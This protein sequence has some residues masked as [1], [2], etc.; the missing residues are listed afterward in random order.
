MD[1]IHWITSSKQSKSR[2]KRQADACRMLV[3]EKNACL[4]F[5]PLR[6]LQQGLLR[7]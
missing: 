7:F 5:G 6:A 4:L 3:T 1:W 2:T